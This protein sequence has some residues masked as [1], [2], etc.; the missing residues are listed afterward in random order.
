M[1]FSLTV[2]HGLI[3]SAVNSKG[4]KA[5][6]LFVCPEYEECLVEVQSYRV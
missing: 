6:G 5:S 4:R 2:P 1:I 3:D